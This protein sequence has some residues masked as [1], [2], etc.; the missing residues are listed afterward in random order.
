MPDD[1]RQA[2]RNAINALRAMPPDA[3]QRAIDSG[4]FS[5]FSPEEREM[6]KGASKLPL[7][8]PEPESPQQ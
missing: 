4:R 8:P 7:A 3:R 1:R 5:Q 2:V 6:L